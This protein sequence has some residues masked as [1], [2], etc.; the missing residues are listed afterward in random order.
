MQRET[1]TFHGREWH[2]FVC[3][4]CQAPIITEKTKSPL[5]VGLVIVCV[6]L[7]ALE[8]VCRISLHAFV[9]GSCIYA[10]MANTTSEGC[11]C[12]SMYFL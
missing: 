4:G 2:L 9:R 11:G 7:F 3:D 10:L 5:Y 1:I 12:V 6:H 8:R